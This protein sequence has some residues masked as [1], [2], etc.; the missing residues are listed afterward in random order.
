MAAKSSAKG[1]GVVAVL[2]DPQRFRL[3]GGFVQFEGLAIV[4]DGVGRPGDKKRRRRGDSRD[5]L[6]RVIARRDE[7]AG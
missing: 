3:A 1:G 7:Q 2:D 4:S 5:V 6:D